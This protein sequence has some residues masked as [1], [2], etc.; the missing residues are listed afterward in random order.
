MAKNKINPRKASKDDPSKKHETD[1][2]T[3]R[4]GVILR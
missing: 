3:T 1:E 4:E 2:G